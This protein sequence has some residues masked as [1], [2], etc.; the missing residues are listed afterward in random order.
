ME[1]KKSHQLYFDVSLRFILMA[2]V[3]KSAKERAKETAN[4]I[5]M[6]GTHIPEAKRTELQLLR[7]RVL[8]CAVNFKWGLYIDD[9]R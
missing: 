6:H 9:M 4:Q 8:P 7:G 1:N 3:R 2:K 5:V